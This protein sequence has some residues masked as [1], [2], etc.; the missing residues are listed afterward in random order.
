MLFTQTQNAHHCHVPREPYF[1]Q[2]R[3]VLMIEDDPLI[4]FVQAELLKQAGF[5]V[6]CASQGKS[7]IR[8]YSDAIDLI[9]CDIELPDML[10]F[11]VASTLRQQGVRIPIIACSSHAIDVSRFPMFTAAIQKP[12][13][14]SHLVS[15]LNRY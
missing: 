5:T 4:Q 2:E 11:D 12:L 15:L 8:Q 6:T 3:H 1:P 13:H 10:G 14:K 9:I 7:G